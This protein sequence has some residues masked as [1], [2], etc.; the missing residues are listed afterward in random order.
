MGWNFYY[1]LTDKNQIV[2]ELT[3][4]EGFLKKAIYGNELWTLWSRSDKKIIILYLLARKNNNWGYKDISESEHPYYYQCP[5][6]FLKEAEEVNKE[7]R[8]KVIEYNKTQSN[9]R[10]MLN[11]IKIGYKVKLKDSNPSEFIVLSITPF[12]G[13]SIIDNN[14]YKLVKSR[15]FEVSE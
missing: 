8:D 10:K 13:R 7:W 1:N 6:S 5:L 14:I 12:I 3:N 9:K 2:K 15:I 11:E 4:N